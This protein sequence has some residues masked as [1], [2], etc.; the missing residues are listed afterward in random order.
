MKQKL[1]WLIT[2]ETLLTAI[3]VLT[4]PYHKV[5]AQPDPVRQPFALAGQVFSV[6]IPGL[7]GEDTLLPG[8]TYVLTATGFTPQDKL[9]LLLGNIGLATGTSNSA[10]K[11]VF[12]IK[13]PSTLVFG[14]YTM[15]V[16]NQVAASAAYLA[17]LDP[18]LA[19]S[20][21]TTYRGSVIRVDGLGFTAVETVTLLIND[22]GNCTTPV[23]YLGAARATSRGVVSLNVTIP[24]TLTAASTYTVVA[25]GTT[26]LT[27]AV[28]P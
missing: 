25:T 22:A 26:S 23:H 18:S 4:F 11:T 27:C 17:Q 19:T 16:R 3:I 15:T 5:S 1:F 10:G 7:E 24:L 2:V 12:T 6:T 14:P 9:T 28:A 8:S 20:V 13:A 21:N